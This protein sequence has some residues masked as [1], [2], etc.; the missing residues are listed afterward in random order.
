MFI[1]AV[2]PNLLVVSLAKETAGVDISWGLW[3]LACIVPGGPPRLPLS[4]L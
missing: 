3:A 4:C 1:T 2:A